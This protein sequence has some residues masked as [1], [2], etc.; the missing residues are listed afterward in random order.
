M[1]KET[2]ELM[3]WKNME[4]QAISVRREAMFQIATAEILFNTAIAHIKELG[5]KT[6]EQEETDAKKIRENQTA[7]DQ[8]DEK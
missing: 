7:P 3:D 6:A 5:G 4:R 2:M 1:K 8:P